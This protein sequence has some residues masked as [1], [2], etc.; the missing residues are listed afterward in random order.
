ML[1]ASILF[2]RLGV[3]V[4]VSGGVTWQERFGRSEAEVAAAMLATLGVPAADVIQ[5]GRSRTTRENAAET[6][7]IMRG[8]GMTRI[9]LVTSA[10]HMPRAMRAFAREGI[11]CVPA[12]TSYRAQEKF[13]G[14]I[15]FLPSFDALRDCFDAFRE[16]CGIVLYAV[17]G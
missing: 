6:A 12:P 2:K 10:V 15:D 17:R 16:Y 1:S 7:K 3:P 14:V 4:I 13:H 11:T 5:E 8:K 9:A